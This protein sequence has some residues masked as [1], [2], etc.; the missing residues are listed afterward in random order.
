MNDLK[1]QNN[2]REEKNLFFLK[3]RFKSNSLN[4]YG[5]FLLIFNTRQELISHYILV[6]TFSSVFDMEPHFGWEKYEEF[7]VN[8]KWKGNY[9]PNMTASVEDFFKK[10]T[11]EEN[12]QKEILYSYVKNYDYDNIDTF[13]FD[14]INRIIHDK[15]LIIE[16]GVQESSEME[17][18][19]TKENRSQKKDAQPQQPDDKKPAD[20]GVTLTIQLI[21][22]PVSGKPMYELKIGD[23]IMCKILP[24]TDR[25]NYFIDLLNLRVENVVK[26]VP[27]KVID[28]K[29]E[30][31]GFALEILT[32]IGPGIY[33]KCIE[34]ERQ[35][36]LRM[37]DPAVD[38]KISNKQIS[39]FKKETGKEQ[40]LSTKINILK[41]FNL[42]KFFYVAIGIFIIAGALIVAFYILIF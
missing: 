35:V 7:I 24:N 13:M 28:I 16:T 36:K 1:N 19:E 33:G 32:E 41:N 37:Y 42:T 29:S 25:A 31:K 9:N 26:P 11:S 4:F 40:S 34:D 8:A 14:I 39:N 21:L 27:G 15:N 22:A 12:G 6:S 18:R 5:L 2:I 17:F 3:G 23:V 20:E 30:G 10:I 38:G